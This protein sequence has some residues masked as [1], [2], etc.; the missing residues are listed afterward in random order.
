M[1]YGDLAHEAET[2]FRGAALAARTTA[3]GPPPEVIDGVPH[4]A[5]CGRK[6]AAARLKA[7]PGCGL[8]TICQD[9]LDRSPR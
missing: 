4:C 1:D 9:K 6:I 8:C 7:I 5:E 2:V 3:F